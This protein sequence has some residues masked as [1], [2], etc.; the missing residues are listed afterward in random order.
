MLFL[1]WSYLF[2]I[3][4]STALASL[5]VY[6]VGQIMAQWKD[7]YTYLILAA[8]ASIHI[9]RPMRYNNGYTIFSSIISGLLSFIPRHIYRKFHWKKQNKTILNYIMILFTILLDA[10]VCINFLITPLAALFPEALLSVSESLGHQTTCAMFSL[11]DNTLTLCGLN[12]LNAMN[13]SRLSILYGTYTFIALDET[14]HAAV[15]YVSIIAGAVI[16]TLTGYRLIT[17]D[18]CDPILMNVVYRIT[19]VNI[20][21]TP[22]NNYPEFPVYYGLT[23]ITHIICSIIE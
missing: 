23:V 13:L 16:T 4:S 19:E 17:Q 8:L 3:F 20:T 14:V 9:F 15:A 7:Q 12:C 6:P 5:S 1:S 22:Q 11:L 21:M 18:Y 2:L 10:T